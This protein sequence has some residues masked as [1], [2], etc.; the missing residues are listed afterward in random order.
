MPTVK[1]REYQHATVDAQA[2]G[3]Q[4]GSFSF[5]K[6]SAIKYKIKAPKKR[7]HDHEGATD[8]FTIDNEDIEASITLAQS[9]YDRFRSFLLQQNPGLGL[10][11]CRFD[12]PVNYG[13]DL[14]ALM[15]D[16]L[17]GV[18]IDEDGRDSQDNQEKLMVELPL[19]VTELVSV[20]DGQEHK[21]I[22]RG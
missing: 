14:S 9:E 4:G 2:S 11:Q 1:G 19:F 8:G 5:K 10:G 17:K 18:M 13:D 12:L 20:I 6:F 3:P 22:E 16:R 21:F 7:S 15:T